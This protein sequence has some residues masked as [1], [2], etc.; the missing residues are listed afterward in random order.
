MLKSGVFAF[1]AGCVACLAAAVPASATVYLWTM[2]GGGDSGSGALVTGAADNGGSDIVSFTGA[3][4]GDP[5]ALLGGQPGGATLSA[6]GA[7]IYDNI[8]YP[9]PDN[10]VFDIN[11]VLFSN[12]GEEG[13]LFYGLGAPGDYS[14]YR[15][16]FDQAYDIEN[17]SVIFT[18]T[19]D[20]SAPVPEPASLAILCAGLAGLAIAR[21]RGCKHGR[22]GGLTARSIV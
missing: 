19:A 15:S 9:P 11:G 21:Y 12:A 2:T 17:N 1:L 10:P 7:Y 5:V 6:D 8:L 22:P 4:D 3:I 20:P 14:Y 16:P 18:L 13:N